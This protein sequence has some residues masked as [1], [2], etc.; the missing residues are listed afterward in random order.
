MGHLSFMFLV[1][2]ATISSPIAQAAPFLVLW[3]FLL[4]QV[5]RRILG[6]NYN[7]YFFWGTIYVLP[8]ELLNFQ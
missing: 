5:Y 2:Q 8:A 7:D 1:N 6:Y 3:P 4:E